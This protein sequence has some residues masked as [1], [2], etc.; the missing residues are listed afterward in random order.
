MHTGEGR[1]VI[2]I[3]D[4]VSG[5]AGFALPGLS[6]VVSLLNKSDKKLE[7]RA[8][9]ENVCSCC[10]ASKDSRVELEELDRRAAKLWL[11]TN[12][13]LS[14]LS[15]PAAF[16]GIAGAA[17]CSIGPQRFIRLAINKSDNSK[18]NT[19]IQLAL[20]GDV[21][22]WDLNLPSFRDRILTLKLVD[23]FQ[24][25]IGMLALDTLTQE[26]KQSLAVL[27]S[28]GIKVFKMDEQWKQHGVPLVA[29][30]RIYLSR[31]K[32]ADTASSLS[33]PPAALGRFLPVATE[34]GILGA[35]Y[36]FLAKHR[37]C[38]SLLSNLN[39]R[40]DHPQS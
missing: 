23:N 2:Q 19:T 21:K 25:R 40:L 27:A 5:G 20:C 24:V 36:D 16:A 4:Q 22:D 38:C 31:P 33:S 17:Y 37:R 3:F 18:G 1:S 13:F 6:D 30:I 11:E 26:A 7:C 35:R 8:D 32:A 12:E 9:G 10:L 14:H 15:L 34:V 29:Q 39:S 28:L